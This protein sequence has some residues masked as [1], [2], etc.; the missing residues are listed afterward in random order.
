MLDNILFSSALAQTAEIATQDAKFS[1]SSFVPLILIFGIFYFLIIRPQ[2]KKIK[3]HQQLINDLKIGN[4]VVTSS[5]IHGTV[6]DI[7]KTNIVDLE[8]AQDVVIKINKMSISDLLKVEDK[9][10][11]NKKEKGKKE[12]AKKDKNSKK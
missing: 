12:K 4:K 1:F 5:G 7:D 10:K 3:D 11:S 2:S 8:I 6:K 9:N